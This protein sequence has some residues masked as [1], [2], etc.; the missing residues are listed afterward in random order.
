M[1]SSVAVL[2]RL[3]H[4]QRENTAA[5][6]KK[7]NYRRTLAQ[8]ERQVAKLEASYA[9]AVRVARRYMSRVKELE[10]ENAFAKTFI[11]DLERENEALLREVTAA[12]GR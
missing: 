11:S 2:A 8:K 6:R 3:D 9:A 5:R 12:G 7:R 1:G 10:R 4:L